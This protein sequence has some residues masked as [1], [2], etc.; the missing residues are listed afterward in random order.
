VLVVDDEST[1]EEEEEL[2]DSVYLEDVIV[3]Y[4]RGQMLP[5]DSKISIVGKN[6]IDRPY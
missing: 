3:H 5:N 1:T 2:E 6:Q 4:M